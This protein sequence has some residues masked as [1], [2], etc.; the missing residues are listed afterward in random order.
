LYQIVVPQLIGGWQHNYSTKTR[1]VG[2]ANEQDIYLC[3]LWVKR[4][5]LFYQD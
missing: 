3:C 2:H 1:Q 5:S 4:S